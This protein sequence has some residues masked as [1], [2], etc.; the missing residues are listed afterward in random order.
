[1]KQV[2][3]IRRERIGSS[4]KMQHIPNLMTAVSVD[5]RIA[6]LK[7]TQNPSDGTLPLSPVDG[8][9]TSSIPSA[10][11]AGRFGPTRWSPM[12]KQR[13]I[14]SRPPLIS[15]DGVDAGAW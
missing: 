6:S 4:R 1:L 15:T 14:N 13:R 11:H 5:G 12:P 8:V 3:V 9:L 7:I 10:V 2:A